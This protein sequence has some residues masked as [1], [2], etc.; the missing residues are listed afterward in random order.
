MCLA[1]VSKLERYIGAAP[2]Q[3]VWKT[4]RLLLHQYREM[5]CRMGNAPTWN[6]L[7]GS[8]ITFLSPTHKWLRIV[9]FNDSKE[10]YETPQ[11]SRTVIRDK[12]VQGLESNQRRK[13]YETFLNL[14]LQAKLGAGAGVALAEFAL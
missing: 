12:W 3:Q 5:E 14:I 13:A 7:E 11:F 1:C 4:R 6:C 2:I 9:E 10:A 8:H